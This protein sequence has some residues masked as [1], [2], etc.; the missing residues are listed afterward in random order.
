MCGQVAQPDR[1]LNAVLVPRR[2]GAY[3]WAE[4]SRDTRPAA[5]REASSPA[6]NDLDSEPISNCVNR[7]T[8]SG[9]P[10]DG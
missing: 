2:D 5:T 9:A 10:E 4:S 8:G 1:R 6:V 3:C 7:V